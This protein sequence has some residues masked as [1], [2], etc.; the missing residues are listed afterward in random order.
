MNEEPYKANEVAPEINVT[1]DFYGVVAELEKMTPIEIIPFSFALNLSLS[2]DKQTI[3][4]N[5]EKGIVICSKAT[6]E[7]I[8]SV[9]ITENRITSFVYSEPK[10]LY[11]IGDQKGSLHFVC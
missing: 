10:S 9:R 6:N 7:V 1:N 2:S 8:K 5:T 11:Y 4:F 3:T